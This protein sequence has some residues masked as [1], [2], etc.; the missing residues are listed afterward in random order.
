MPQAET[1]NAIDTASNPNATPTRSSQV[2]VAPASRQ[3]LRQFLR[4]LARACRQALPAAPAGRCAP[5]PMIKAAKSCQRP[6]GRA[7]LRSPLARI[8]Q[9]Y[10]SRPVLEPP[11]PRDR[12]IAWTGVI[13]V[14]L[15]ALWVFAPF[16]ADVRAM[17]FQ[18]WDS[19]AAYRYVTVLALRHGQAPWWNPWYCG[20]FP[21]WGYVEGATNFVS[22]WL[23][24]YLLAPFPLALRLEAVAATFAGVLGASD[25]LRTHVAPRLRLDAVR[26]LLPRPRGGR[27]SPRPGG[28]GRGDAGAHHLRGRHLPVPAHADGALALRARAGHRRAQPAA[29]GALS[30]VDVHR[31]RPGGAQAAARAVDHVALSADHRIERAGVA[32]LGLDHADRAPA[33]VRLLPAP[34]AAG[35]LGLVGVGGLRRRR[36]RAGADRGA[37]GRLDAAPRVAQGGGDLL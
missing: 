32:A 5:R 34:A 33:G 37:G 4:Q 10:E 1:A 3:F 15:L 14:L 22:P 36:R 26:H 8:A 12:L 23:P 18:D 17:G 20:G 9:P 24:F 7:S 27:R 25:R 31:H 11:R 16:F 19:Q 29:A 30:A 28:G 2:I 21:A 35:L 6:P 13:P